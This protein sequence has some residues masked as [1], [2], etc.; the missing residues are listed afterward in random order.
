MTNSSIYFKHALVHL[1]SRTT[2]L[3]LHGSL[4]LII[5][6]FFK[7]GSLNNNVTLFHSQPAL[8]KYMIESIYTGR[9]FPGPLLDPSSF[10]RV[11]LNNQFVVHMEMLRIGR[12][13]K[14]DSIENKAYWFLTDNVKL[15]GQK[16]QPDNDFSQAIRWLYS[17]PQK[18]DTD[19]RFQI[20]FWL[21]ISRASFTPA[22]YQNIQHS[23]AMVPQFGHELS[24]RANE[25]V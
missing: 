2:P 10:S 19:I 16:L 13:Y 17:S 25:I 5:L 11:P 21:H 7:G 24:Q 6:H 22:G 15:H 14:I 8:L 23:A 20:T 12:L 3:C 18:G 1:V 4:I 9:Y